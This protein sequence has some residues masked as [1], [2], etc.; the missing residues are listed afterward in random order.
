MYVKQM[1][2]IFSTIKNEL[3]ICEEQV[4]IDRQDGDTNNIETREIPL[5]P[6]YSLTKN[7][8]DQ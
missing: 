2:F 4:S 6:L 8:I 1:Y 7:E 5:Q 3:D